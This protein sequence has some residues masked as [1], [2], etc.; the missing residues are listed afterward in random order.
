MFEKSSSDL[1]GH[2]C[3]RSLIK[4]R[5]D[6]VTCHCHSKGHMSLSLAALSHST[7]TMSFPAGE[8]QGCSEEQ[9]A[10][11]CHYPDNCRHVSNSSVGRYCVA[12]SNYKWTDL[13]SYIRTPIFVAFGLYSK[14]S[15][16]KPL[17]RQINENLND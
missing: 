5:D 9:N 6:A 13:H 8:E 16:K 11:Q 14:C 1:L 7:A 12:E 10:H 15:E 2:I 17:I 4:V 3:H